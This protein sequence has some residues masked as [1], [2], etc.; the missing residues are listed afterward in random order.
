MA[1]RWLCDS[2]SF[3][4]RWLFFLCSLLRQ[5]G[6][7]LVLSDSSLDSSRKTM[8]PRRSARATANVYASTPAHRLGGELQLSQTPSRVA[9][10]DEMQHD[11]LRFTIVD[12]IPLHLESIWYFPLGC[13]NRCRLNVIRKIIPSSQD[14][15][16]EDTDRLTSSWYRIT[17]TFEEKFRSQFC[18]ND[19]DLLKMVFRPTNKDI[20]AL[21]NPYIE[22]WNKFCVLAAL[23]DRLLWLLANMNALFPSGPILMPYRAAPL[24]VP[25]DCPIKALYSAQISWKQEL[26]RYVSL[27]TASLSL[28]GRA[29][30]SSRPISWPV[31]PHSFSVPTSETARDE[32]VSASLLADPMRQGEDDFLAD[33]ELAFRRVAFAL[34][35]VLV[36]SRLLCMRPIDVYL[37]VFAQSYDPL[38]EADYISDAIG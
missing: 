23:H 24:S 4:S 27:F 12:V 10:M 16:P 35:A 33:V 5:R 2:V 9:L 29:I 15:Y 3:S 21:P 38:D 17:N 14:I 7:L 25:D 26:S 28:R 11:K 6:T 18:D 36:V 34:R 22:W 30:S 19:D 37:F 20:L 1:T 8:P 31:R 13:R 32:S